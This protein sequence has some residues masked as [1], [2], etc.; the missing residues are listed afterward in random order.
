MHWAAALSSAHSQT[1]EFFL[2]V[3]AQSSPAFL[4]TF[5]NRQ[6]GGRDFLGRD[7]SLFSFVIKCFLM[8]LSVSI[9]ITFF[10]PFLN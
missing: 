5:Y 4:G 10:I 7:K 6:E 9:K 3:A 8:K 2:F 1:S